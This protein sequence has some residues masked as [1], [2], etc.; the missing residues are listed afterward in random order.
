M[1]TIRLADLYNINIE[2]WDEEWTIEKMISI[3]S[4]LNI[5][6]Q[7]LKSKEIINDVSNRY[8]KQLQKRYMS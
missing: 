3:Q 7:I 8:D 1:I 6:K 5:E 4:S 2:D